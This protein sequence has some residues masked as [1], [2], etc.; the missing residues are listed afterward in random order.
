MVSTAMKALSSEQKENYREMGKHMF[1]TDFNEVLPK[2]VSNIE[3]S[4]SDGIFYIN[5]ALKSG[6]HPVELSEKET[7]LLHDIYG[8]QWYEKYGYDEDD[9]GLKDIIARTEKAPNDFEQN[10]KTNVKPPRTNRKKKNK[11]WGKH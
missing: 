8:P 5:E 7:Q 6:L 3:D 4:L 9:E 1:K 10:T 11:K 2:P